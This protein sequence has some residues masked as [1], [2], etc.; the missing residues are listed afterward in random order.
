[1]FGVRWKAYDQDKLVGELFKSTSLEVLHFIPQIVI[2]SNVYT[3][4][5]FFIVKQVSDRILHKAPMLHLDHTFKKSRDMAK[6][7]GK[8]LGCYLALKQPFNTQSVTLLGFSLGT[9]VIKYALRVLSEL[10]V[11]DVIEN[12][13]CL[14]GAAIQHEDDFY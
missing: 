3:T 13:I 1:M 6:V 8:L 4:L 5:G 7:T 12:V 14:G 2:K 10:E 9:Q 11:D